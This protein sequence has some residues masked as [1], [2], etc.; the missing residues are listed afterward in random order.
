MRFIDHS[1]RM[2]RD[3]WR[4]VFERIHLPVKYWSSTIAKIADQP[5]KGP[6]LDYWKVAPKHISEGRGLFLYGPFGSGKTSLA[7]LIVKRAAQYGQIGYWVRMDDLISEMMDKAQFDATTTCTDRAREAPLLVVDEVIIRENVRFKETHLEE[8]I[9]YRVDQKLATVL[10]SNDS[11]TKI[12]R[13]IP[14]MSSILSDKAFLHLNVAG[15]DMRGE[16]ETL[17]D[18]PDRKEI[19]KKPRKSGPRSVDESWS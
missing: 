16:A 15:E 1:S 6:F 9:R 14:G 10:T 3:D 7:A 11:P 19:I 18:Y 13:L 5:H 17:L 12:C 4:K 2:S 8:T